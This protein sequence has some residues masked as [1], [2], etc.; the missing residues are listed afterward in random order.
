LLRAGGTAREA[1]W[2]ND[3]L[4]GVQ[5][6]CPNMARNR[7]ETGLAGKRWDNRPG[8]HEERLSRD[9]EGVF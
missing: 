7:E 8:R 5:V 3:L 9:V 1:L 2:A 4:V 6:V